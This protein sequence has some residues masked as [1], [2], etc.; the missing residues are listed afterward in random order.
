MS[1]QQDLIFAVQPELTRLQ[2][3]QQSFSETSAINSRLALISVLGPESYRD[4]T[5]SLV[6]TSGQTIPTAFE[7]DGSY[8]IL[9]EPL[10]YEQSNQQFVTIRAEDVDGFA[11]ETTLE[12]GILDEN[13]PLKLSLSTL[14]I[15]RISHPIGCRY[16]YFRRSDSDDVLTY[17]LIDDDFTTLCFFLS[18]INWIS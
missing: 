14:S 15:P 17:S 7:I 10:D 3:S 5:F 9:L 12:L 18:A 8:L 13:E 4:F 11:L 1:F 2:L 6:A 16:I